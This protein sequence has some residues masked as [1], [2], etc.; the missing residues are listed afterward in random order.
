MSSGWFLIK[1]CCIFIYLLETVI[2][3]KL[4]E[5]SELGRTYEN[6]GVQFLRL[7]WFIEEVSEI[8]LLELLSVAVNV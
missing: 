1:W 8:T 7:S 5:Y 3:H 2:I 6:H 4:I